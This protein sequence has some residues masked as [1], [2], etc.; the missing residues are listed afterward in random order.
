MPELPDISLYVEKID[1]RIRG[2]F[3]TNIRISKPFL[4]RSYD[5]PL[6]V[7]NKRRVTEIRRVGKRRAG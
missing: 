3:L 4:V 7:A 1:E 6:D 5:P 2:Q